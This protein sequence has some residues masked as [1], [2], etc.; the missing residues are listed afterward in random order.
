MIYFYKKICGLKKAEKI[1]ALLIIS[2]II[3]HLLVWALEWQFGE[4]FFPLSKKTVTYSD[5]F[6]PNI[7]AGYFEH[8]QY[9]LLLWC[10]ML[11]TVWIFSRRLWSAFSIPI[12]Y[13][14]L[15]IDDSLQLHDK[16]YEHM[17]KMFS[18]EQ[19]L[20]LD[21]Y[22]KAKDFAEP[23]YWSLVVLI[24]FIISLPA[25]IKSDVE[26]KS[27]IFKNYFLFSLMAFFGIFIDFFA[28]NISNA[29]AI[30]NNDIRFYVG[31]LMI[32]VEE[33]GEMATI[34][35]ACIWLFY[36]NLYK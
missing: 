31:I 10:M 8:Y 16:S 5:L 4:V 32:L 25:I 22:M 15:L 35:L 23:M 33:V 30:Q 28:A 1:F 13:L 24:I 11:S 3:F 19:M 36:I 26:I 21:K 12:V 27:F 14:F 9:L 17:V 18:A 29:F 34:G 7:D 6:A 2:G 20:F